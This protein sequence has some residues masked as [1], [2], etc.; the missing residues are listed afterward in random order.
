MENIN[1]KKFE[2]IKAE[3]IDGFISI[4]ADKPT[5]R[6]VKDAA[7]NVI[8]YLDVKIEGYA[9]TFEV[10][11]GNE[12]VIPG[13]FAEHLE[14]YLENPILL[15]DHDRDTKSACGLVR[16][17]YEDSVGLRVSGMLTN[18]PDPKMRDLRFKVVEGVLR[19]FSIGGLFY[20]KALGDKII[21]Y[22]VELREISI[23]TVPMN[24]KSLF[25]VKQEAA[26][27]QLPTT[28]G[29]EKMDKASTEVGSKAVIIDG[30]KLKKDGITVWR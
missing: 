16:A 4:K 20:G 3:K 2:G 18:S 15:C 30:K 10:D 27:N 19:T 5:Y 22:K 6:E 24:K 7:G 25:E 12:Q 17:A 21:L 8:D 14:E 23:V 9:N 13:A 29:P 11:R 26:G 1:D 28:P